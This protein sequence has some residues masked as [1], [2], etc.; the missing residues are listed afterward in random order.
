MNS[1]ASSAPPQRR[2]WLRRLLKMGAGGLLLVLMAVFLAKR[3]I[4]DALARNL[5]ERLSAAG[6]FI[7]WK[8]AAWMPGPGIRLHDVEIF[9]DAAKTD[10]LAMLSNIAAIKAGSGWSHWDTF[11]VEARRAKLVL[12][13]G[14]NETA[15]S[16]L[17]LDLVI[18]PGKA[19]VEDFQAM[20]LGWKVE[21]KGEYLNPSS[22]KPGA[23][24]PAEASHGERSLLGDV[25]L[26]WLRSVKEWGSVHATKEAPVIKIDFRSVPETAAM[27]LALNVSGHSFRWRD[28]Q[29]DSM[30]ASVKGAMGKETTPI[31]ID[32]IEIGHGGRTAR[33]TGSVNLKEHAVY[34]SKFESGMD[35]LA[36]ARAFAPGAAKS[37]ASMT[38][39]GQW[40]ISGTGKIRM[41]EPRTSQWKGR[42]VVSGDVTY[43]ADKKRVT[44][45]QPALELALA[46]GVVTIADFKAGLWGGQITLPSST[47]HLGEGAAP[48]AFLTKVVLSNASMQ[49][50]SK[51]LGS[52]A[53]QP[54]VVNANWEGGG[55]FTLPSIA[56]A[57]TVSIRQA[58][59]Y[60]VPLLGPLHLVFDRLTPGFGKDVASS[61]TANHSLRNSVLSIRN[62][63]LD[64]KFTRVEANGDVDLERNHAHLTAKAK[65][66]GIVGLATAL[67]SALLEV[68][69]D[70][71][72]N[73]VKWTLKNLPAGALVKGA[74]DIVGKTG[75]AV[76]DGTGAAVRATGGAAAGTVKEAGKAVKGILKLPGRLLPGGGK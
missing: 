21:A 38:T 53:N 63:H 74:A 39:S 61:L 57:G 6:I 55:G 49:A 50:I 71:P 45:Q 18:Q 60:R 20:L 26:D 54:G 36:L 42:I 48:P 70:G 66:Q 37:L 69:G 58:E 5:D 9:R 65:L 24:T 22:S 15:M 35:I 40:D 16:D 12:D 30:A 75:G 62:L 1:E 19:T 13:H 32:R 7:A 2:R 23:T 17:H 73:D 28:Q 4:G 67:L 33:L 72:P 41:D 27:K 46:K 47:I 10:R 8:S 14:E 11:K 3:Q 76:I 34:V 64:S 44:L 29:W 68:E 25:H 59:F 52:G 51:D 31:E 43:A 56:G